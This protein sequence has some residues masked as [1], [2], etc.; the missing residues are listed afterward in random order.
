M[1]NGLI[2][3]LGEKVVATLGDNKDNYRYKAWTCGALGVQD[4]LVQVARD[5]RALVLVLV[6]TLLCSQSVGKAGCDITG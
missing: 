1:V 6:L 4:F 5:H 2:S 3:E